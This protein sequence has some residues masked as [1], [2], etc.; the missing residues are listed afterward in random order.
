MYPYFQNPLFKWLFSSHSCKWFEQV[1]LK[2]MAGVQMCSFALHRRCSWRFLSCPL[3]KFHCF[4]CHSGWR[5]E[6]HLQ[7]APPLGHFKNQK[8]IN[9]IMCRNTSIVNGKVIVEDD[10]PGRG[11]CCAQEKQSIVVGW[12]FSVPHLHEEPIFHLWKGS[13]VTDSKNRHSFARLCLFWT[14]PILIGHTCLPVKR[15]FWLS[16]T[17]H[18]NQY[19]RKCNEQWCKSRV[20]TNQVMKYP[21]L[22]RDVKSPTPELK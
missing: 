10:R 9:T 8:I 4:N 2:W 17:G 19:M 12:R 11:G 6:T 5:E 3:N 1:P 7:H 15:Y 16:Y 20:K 21:Q 18:Q 22:G 13:K 14:E